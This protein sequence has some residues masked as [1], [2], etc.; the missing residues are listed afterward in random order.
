[1]VRQENVEGLKAVEENMSS[2]SQASAPLKTVPFI[3]SSSYTFWQKLLLCVA[4]SVVLTLSAKIIIPCWPVNATLQNLAVIMLGAIY[5]RKLATFSVLLYLAEGAC[6]LPVFTSTPIQGIGLAYMMGPSAG[7]LFGFILMAYAAGLL[8]ENGWGSTLFKAVILCLIAN[9]VLYIPGI[10]WLSLC[11]GPK[12][13]L[14]NAT[15]WIPGFLTKMGL[16]VALFLQLTSLKAR[17]S[18]SDILS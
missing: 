8:Y 12:A 10:L 9:L 2:M 3:N 1:M 17:S 7:F 5:G 4:G 16:A 14:A 11:I 18:T 15:L 13:A 6:G